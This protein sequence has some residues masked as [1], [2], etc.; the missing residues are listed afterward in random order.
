MK[1][2]QTTLE[3][4]IFLVLVTI[5]CVGLSHLWNRSAIINA[6]T[7]GVEDNQ[8]KVHVRSMTE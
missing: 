1:K 3:Y 5:I 4:V 6:G 2:A 8:N 7:F